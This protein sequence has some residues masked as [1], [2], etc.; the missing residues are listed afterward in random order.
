MT[1]KEVLEHEKNKK[2]LEM[3]IGDKTKSDTVQVDSKDD[4]RF[5]SGDRDFAVDPT[6]KEFKK[7]VQGHN[8]VVKR[9]NY[10]GKKR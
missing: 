7:V 1:E 8:K 2:Q 6:H 3:L 9:S 10:Q 5:T 4:Q